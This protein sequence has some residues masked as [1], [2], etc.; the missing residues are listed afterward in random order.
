[1][2]DY[3]LSF[4][5]W[6]ENQKAHRTHYRAECLNAYISKT[7]RDR[8]LVTEEHVQ[9]TDAA[10]SNGVIKFDLDLIFQG[11]MADLIKNMQ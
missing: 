8:V 9:E 3:F 11:Q 5:K 4:S 6:S 7:I 1:M 2:A 10:L